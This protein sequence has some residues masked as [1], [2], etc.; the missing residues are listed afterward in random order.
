MAARRER[1]GLELTHALARQPDL[2][3]DRVERPRGGESRD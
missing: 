2:V 1:L 3:A